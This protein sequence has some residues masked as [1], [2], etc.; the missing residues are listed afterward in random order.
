MPSARLAR[1]SYTYVLE[2]EMARALTVAGKAKTPKALLRETVSFC[3][4]S[5]R[6]LRSGRRPEEVM[7]AEDD[8]P[9]TG[10]VAAWLPGV[11]W[12]I[13]DYILHGR[14]MGCRFFVALLA[15]GSV[16]PGGNVRLGSSVHCIAAGCRRERQVPAL[17]CLKHVGK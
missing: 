7:G 2:R 10:L 16:L 1:S 15:R 17:P 5:P 9:P 3:S 12:R 11:S 14:V 4:S 13:P 6:E 8:T